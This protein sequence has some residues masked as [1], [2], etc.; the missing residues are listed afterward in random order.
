M[1]KENNIQIYADEAALSEGAVRLIINIANTAILQQGRCSI[2]LSGGNTPQSVYALLATSPLCD[3]IAWDKIFFFW[4]DERCVPSNDEQSNYYHAKEILL[5]K[6]SIPK[7]NI[8]PIYCYASPSNAAF[9]YEETLR[10]SLGDW[11]PRLDLILLGLGENGH[12]ASLFPGHKTALYDERLV[13]NVF[14]PEQDMH[15]VSMTS[16]LINHAANIIFLVSGAGKA[17]I[18]QCTISGAYD[19]ANIPAQTIHPDDG[20]LYWLVDEQAAAL[21]PKDTL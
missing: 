8:F 1:N 21:L 3:E 15:R 20:T 14:V 18:L 5:D 6:I 16:Y 4:G 2:A 11:H 9:R 12:T 7:E 17:A 19:P 10:T 13:V